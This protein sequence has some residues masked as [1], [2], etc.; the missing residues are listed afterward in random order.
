MRR[1]VLWFLVVVSPVFFAGF[2]QTAQPGGVVDKGTDPLDRA[3][4]RRPRPEMH[5][6]PPV[7]DS[8]LKRARSTSPAGVY[9]RGGYTSVQVNVDA[10]GLNIV[11]DAAN[12]PSLAVDPNNPARMAIGWRQFDTI[13]SDFRKGGWAYSGD[14]GQTWTFPGVIHPTEF[15]SDPVLESDADGNFYYYSLQLDRGPGEWA[16]YMYRSEDHGMTWPQDVYAWGGDKG[17]FTID[18]TDGPGRGHIYAAWN[19]FAGC[20]VP[21]TFN[22]STNGGLSFSTPMIIPELPG[23]GTLTVGPDGAL[24]VAGMLTTNFAQIAVVRSSNA[25]FADEPVIF[26]QAVI[27]TLGGP[28]MFDAGPNPDGLLGQIWIASDHSD[29]P[30][31]GNLYLL[32]SINPG[33]PGGDDPLDVMFSR[34]TDRGLTWSDPVR[35]NDDPPEVY[36]WQWFG[37]MSVAPNG[38][39]D[40]IWNDTRNDRFGYD[41]EL[42]YSSSIDAGMTWSPNVAL[43]PPFDPHVGWPQ[44]AKLGDYYDMDSDDFGVSIAYAATFNGEQDVYYL[45]IGDMD[46]NGNGVPDPDDVAGGTSGDCNSNDVPDECEPD[47]ND[48]GTVDVCD[49]LAGTSSD[50]DRNRNPDEC[51]SDFDGDGTIDGC[52]SDVDGDGV[53]NR[54]DD[55]PFTPLGIP[56]GLVGQ[57]ISDTNGNCVVDLADYKRFVSCLNT[58]GPNIPLGRDCTQFHDYDGDRDVDLQDAAGFQYA[59]GQ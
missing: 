54:D 26:D 53:P 30:T 40:V 35:I 7:S 23:F 21:N 2:A 39:I 13:A 38:R 42:Y 33:S 10:D 15:A 31:R 5:E 48:N 17:W 51:D 9:V 47:C 41:S 52:D 25:Q 36:S 1:S 24:Y 28:V 4:I 11:A 57:P 3:A 6:D 45:R 43:S 19:P 12:E 8:I 34:S 56:V 16:C 44:Q 14:S 46:C 18:R 55:C 50:C 37:T 58:G 49:I 59:F 20:C 22:R 29:G 27:T 32:A